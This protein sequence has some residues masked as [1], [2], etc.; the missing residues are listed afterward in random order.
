MED[1]LKEI[2]QRLKFH[3]E[4]EPISIKDLAK[5]IGIGYSTLLNFLYNDKKIVGRVVLLKFKRFF[6]TKGLS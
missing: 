4:V 3:L 5:E 2:R 1:E 6:K